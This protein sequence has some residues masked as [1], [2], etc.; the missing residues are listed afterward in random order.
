MD[1][2]YVKPLKSENLINDF[3]RLI[4]YEF[5]KEFRNCVLQFN[6][7]RPE[8][9]EFETSMSSGIELKSFLSFNVDDKE[10]VWKIYEWNKDEL[11]NKYAAFAIDNFGN[12]IC[13]DTDNGK[14]VFLNHENLSIEH[15]ANTFAEFMKLLHG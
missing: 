15:I 8:R 14:V 12:L 3:E 7:E 6:G 5:P 4:C 1:W 10:T 11:S 13:F 9:R 2:K